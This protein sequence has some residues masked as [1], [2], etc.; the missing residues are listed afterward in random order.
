MNYKIYYRIVLIYFEWIVNMLC[1]LISGGEKGQGS[2]P[3]V[4]HY[5]VKL[6]FFLGS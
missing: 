4:S 5:I 6:M 3:D 1:M 2:G